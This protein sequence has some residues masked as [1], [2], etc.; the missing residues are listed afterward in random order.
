MPE[1]HQ[2]VPDFAWFFIEVD[3]TTFTSVNLKPVLSGFSI[4]AEALQKNAERTCLTEAAFVRLLIKGFM[5]KE[6]PDEQ[7]YKEMKQLAAIGNNINQIAAKVNST[8]EIDGERLKTEVE[9]LKAFRLAL[10]KK[11]LEPDEAEWL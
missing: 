3:F 5:P 2:H 8:G 11:Y 4:A 6:R 7:F 9:A 10:M 1:K